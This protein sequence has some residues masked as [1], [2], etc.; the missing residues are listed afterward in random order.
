M[1]RQAEIGVKLLEAKEYQEPPKV[2]RRR[3]GGGHRIEL[4]EELWP[5]TLYFQSFK[6]QNCKQIIFCYL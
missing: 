1:K 2:G 5:L 4:L 3:R 6:C